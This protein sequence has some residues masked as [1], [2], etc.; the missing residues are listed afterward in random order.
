M[1]H[2]LADKFFDKYFHVPAFVIWSA[3]IISGFLVYRH[4][5]KEP[6]KK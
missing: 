6:E 1:K 3:L 5:K 4:S 2:E